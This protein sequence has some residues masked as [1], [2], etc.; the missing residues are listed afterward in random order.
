[1]RPGNLQI[2]PDVISSG[3]FSWLIFSVAFGLSVL[4]VPPLVISIAHQDLWLAMLVGLFGDLVVAAILHVLAQEFPGETFV[5]YSQTILGRWGGLLVAA[6]YLTFL[7]WVNAMNLRVIGDFVATLM[8]GTPPVAIV[9]LLGIFA[10]SAARSGLE[11]LGRIGQLVMP[12]IVAIGLVVVILAA[13]EL[14]LRE[15]LPPF[16]YGVQPAL[17]ASLITLSFFGVCVVM[18][19]FIPYYHRPETAFY[20]KA[21]GVTGAVLL[22]TYLMLGTYAAFGLLTE[23][24]EFPLLNMVQLINLAEFFQRV[25]ILALGF[26]LVST[27]VAVAILFWV[28]ALGIAQCCGLNN[29]RPLV[30]PV[31]L[32]TGGFAFLF[33]DSLMDERDFIRRGYPLVAISVELGL[34]LLLL[35][36]ALLTGKGRR[37]IHPVFT[38]P[39]PSEAKETPDKG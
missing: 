15:L 36:V 8:P 33:F 34:P 13:N 29:Y 2:E 24:L 1:M 26:W 22:M 19:M 6:I 14:D 12:I 31:L 27:Y 38:W 39:R 18:G 4:H 7:L 25:E 17:S 23:Y 3:Q 11:V 5:Q 10:A 32:L 21:L 37:R 28:V 30:Y 20:T 35:G 16:E 9:V